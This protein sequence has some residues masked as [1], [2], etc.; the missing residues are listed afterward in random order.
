MLGVNKFIIFFTSLI[1]ITLSKITLIEYPYPIVYRGEYQT[2]SWYSKNNYNSTTIDLYK[3]NIYLNNLEKTNN[4]DNYFK[5][6][7]SNK[8][9][10]GNKFQLKIT[11]T[12]NI[13]S[14]FIYTPYFYIDDILYDYSY[15]LFNLGFFIFFIMICCCSWTFCC[16][17]LNNQHLP[18]KNPSFNYIHYPK[19]FTSTN[20]INK[21]TCDV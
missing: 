1:N 17:I 2:I 8:V 20:P 3:D 9:K 21:V 5:W 6:L 4:I 12:N 14:D 15:N 16:R 10:L 7:V 11:L 18:E 19:K 13:T